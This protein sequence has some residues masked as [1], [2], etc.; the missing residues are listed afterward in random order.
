MRD[1]SFDRTIERNC[2]QQ[3]RFVIVGQEAVKAGNRCINS[4]SAS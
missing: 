2:L 4:I 3:W 1:N